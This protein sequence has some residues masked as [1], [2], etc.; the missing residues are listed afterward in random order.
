MMKNAIAHWLQ[1]VTARV[2]P[3]RSAGDVPPGPVPPPAPRQHLAV[4]PELVQAWED[5]YTHSILPAAGQP[6]GDRNM[7]AD[8]AGGEINGLLGDAGLLAAIRARIAEVEQR[9][10]VITVTG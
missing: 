6:A 4:S 1:T 8:P 2:M 10:M 3:A 9:G 5:D 7:P